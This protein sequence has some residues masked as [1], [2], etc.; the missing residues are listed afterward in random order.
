MS[1][2]WGGGLKAEL[3]S[4][5]FNESI[6]DSAWT[7]WSL[8]NT[9]PPAPGPTPSEPTPS[10]PTP[11]PSP[12]PPTNCGSRR[13]IPCHADRTMDCAIRSVALEKASKLIP[14]SAKTVFDALE[15]GPLCN[16][17]HHQPDVKPA[18]Q[19]ESAPGHR[20]VHSSLIL[21]GAALSELYVSPEAA[22]GGDGSEAR[23][24]RT[25]QDAVLQSRQ[26]ASGIAMI[27]LRNGTYHLPCTLVLTPQDSGLHFTNYEGENAVV[28]GAAALR[29]ITWVP[30]DRHSTGTF[31]TKLPRHTPHFDQ[32]FVSGVPQIRARYTSQSFSRSL[33]SCQ[34]LV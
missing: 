22:A 8:S 14:S 33:S 23:P 1:P 16:K 12:P 10:Y 15:L 34:L 6:P 20:R 28:S 4:T 11:P 25:I 3:Y 13:S 26:R 21:R 18:S 2:A 9:P 30:S 29:N 27:V 7:L 17:T 19:V 31:M 32:M 5:D 24:F